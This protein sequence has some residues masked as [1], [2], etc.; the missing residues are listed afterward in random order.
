TLIQTG[1]IQDFPLVL[2]GKA[3][4]EP[5]LLFIRSTLVSVGTIGPGDAARI[6]VTDSVEEAVELVRGAGVEKF[7]LRYG[8]PIRRRWWLGE[9]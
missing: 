5:M 3:F 7:G 2:M 9:R 1:K 8:A 4:W 6:V